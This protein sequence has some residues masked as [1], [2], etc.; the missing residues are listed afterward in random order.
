MQAQCNPAHGGVGAA[1]GAPGGGH[2]PAA[3]AGGRLGEGGPR[4]A[5]ASRAAA[6]LAARRPAQPRR[7][8]RLLMI[9][10]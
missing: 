7:E 3:R 6:R 4:P 10:M 1:P 5:R 2:V 8:T 9:S